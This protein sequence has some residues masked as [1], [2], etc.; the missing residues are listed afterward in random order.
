MDRLPKRCEFIRISRHAV[1]KR[2]WMKKSTFRS[3]G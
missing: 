3:L 1:E 2:R